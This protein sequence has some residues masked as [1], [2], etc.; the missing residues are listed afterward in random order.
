MS[1]SIPLTWSPVVLAMLTIAL[2]YSA[3]NAAACAKAMVEE[4]RSEAIPENPGTTDAIYA[5]PR[6]MDACFDSLRLQ[7]V[8]PYLPNTRVALLEDIHQWVNDPNSQTIL[9][10]QGL[11]GTG[12]TT[13]AKTIAQDLHQQGS[14]AGSFFFSRRRDN[15]RSAEKLHS[16]LA[17]QLATRSYPAHFLMRYRSLLHEAVNPDP[18]IFSKAYREQWKHLIMSPLSQLDQGTVSRQS[19]SLVFVIDAVDECE[20][21]TD[22]SPILQLLIQAARL[23]TV[24]V[25]F[26]VTSRPERSVHHAIHRV[27][28]NLKLRLLH[29]IE[30]SVVSGD[31]RIFVE[32]GFGI[33]AEEHRS[34]GC[35]VGGPLPGMLRRHC[36][37]DREREHRL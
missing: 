16:T 21:I 25:R 19:T 34:P 20:P 13:I 22:I 24:K 35:K 33:I 9:W 10:L 23:K 31:I 17:Y 18:D 11:A 26:F 8:H 12:K 2:Q 15:C 1:R 7:Y 5:I 14:L 36:A 30:S 29:E 4:W 37:V 27:R 28:E 6:V 3:V 32:H